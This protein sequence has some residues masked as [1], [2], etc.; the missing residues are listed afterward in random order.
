MRRQG[1]GLAHD[2]EDAYS[3][4]HVKK[5]LVYPRRMAL[6]VH[7]AV[8]DQSTTV[9]DWTDDWLLL[10]GCFAGMLTKTA[11]AVIMA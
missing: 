5:A 6:V 2:V 3:T 4:E 10:N 9:R 1:S 11:K 8:E 7:P